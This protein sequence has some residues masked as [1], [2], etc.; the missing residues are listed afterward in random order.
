MKKTLCL[1]LTLSAIS[2]FSQNSK[3]IEDGG[4]GP[5]KAM[6]V[7]EKSLPQHSIFRPTDLSK[8][9]KLP[10][11][12]WGNGGCS[13]S[14]DNYQNF[15]NEIASRGYMV[16]AN[17]PFVPQGDSLSAED[18]KKRTTSKML[19]ESVDW[20]TAQNTNKNSPYFKK[21]DLENIA[22]AGMSCGGLQAIEVAGDRRFKTTLVLNSGVLNAPPPAN[23]GQMPA[24]TKEKLKDIPTPTLYVIGDSTDIAYKNAMDDFGRINHVPVVM[25]NLNVGHSGTYRQP[26]GGAFAP[27]ILDWLDW[28]MKEK[29]ENAKLFLG[30]NCGWCKKDGWRIETKNFNAKYD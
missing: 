19:L 28:Q 11:I 22:V 8:I 2:G 20:I 1:F 27:L 10:V 26:H 18:Q 24:A 12:V 4:T 7:G 6:V 21:I 14:S 23:M 30:T 13:N 17:G 5:Y 29:N 9:K 25:A 3:I 15:L 16:L